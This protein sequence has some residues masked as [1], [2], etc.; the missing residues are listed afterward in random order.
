[1][2]ALK[3]DPLALMRG[4][5]ARPEEGEGFSPE[6]IRAR[7]IAGR[8]P[9]PGRF[10]AELAL[11]LAAEEPIDRVEIEAL[12]RGYSEA[13]DQVEGARAAL[14]RAIENLQWLREGPRRPRKERSED[15]GGK[16]L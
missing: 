11:R 2:K 16:R 12:L 5:P 3:N 1:M 14:G 10:V 15:V 8:R 7:A 6:E 13:V 4:G 9:L